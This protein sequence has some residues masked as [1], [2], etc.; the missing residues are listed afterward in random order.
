M[1]ARGF[2]LIELMIVVAVVAIIA[3]I[4]FPSYQNQVQ[5]TRRA[6]AHTALLGAAQTLERCFTRNNSYLNCDVPNTSPDGFYTITVQVEQDQPT[7]FEAIAEAIGP[8]KN[9]AEACLK[10]TIN[11]VGQRTPTNGARCWGS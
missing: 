4:A 2:T 8:Q 11:H 9:D 3:A 1:K 7:R 10:M 6:D 5:K